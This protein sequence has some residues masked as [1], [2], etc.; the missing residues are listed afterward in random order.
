MTTFQLFQSCIAD[1]EA[2][3]GFPRS[4]VR[5][6]ALEATTGK[7]GPNVSI[8]VDFLFASAQLRQAGI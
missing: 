1:I 4:I 7:Y 6:V 8:E 5:P 3:T 2:Q